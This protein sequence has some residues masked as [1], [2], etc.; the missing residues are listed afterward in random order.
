MI[1]SFRAGPAGEL[2]AVHVIHQ[3]GIT[4]IRAVSLCSVDTD[5]GAGVYQVADWAFDGRPKY[6][7]IPICGKCVAAVAQLSKVPP[8]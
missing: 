3:K 4:A 1:T 6:G 7:E 8:K 2:H 5:A